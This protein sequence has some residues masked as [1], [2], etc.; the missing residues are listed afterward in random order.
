M[1]TGVTKKLVMRGLH[2]LLGDDLERATMAFQGMTPE[3]MREQHGASGMTRADV[4]LGYQ[5]NA[6]RVNDAIREVNAL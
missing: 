2:N 1:M 5:K 4:L 6:D 3:Q